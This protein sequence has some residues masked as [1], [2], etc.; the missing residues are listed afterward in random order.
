MLR[1]PREL[2]RRKRAI[3][4]GESF[5]ELSD[6]E[7]DGSDDEALQVTGV[8]NPEDIMALAKRKRQ[9]KAEKLEKIIAGRTLFETKQRDGGAT[10]NEKKRTKNFMM[11]KYS[12]DNRKKGSGKTALNSK[13]TSKAYGHD[14]RKR[15]RKM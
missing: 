12:R 1:D 11:S 6:D 14:A 5:V 10:N 3:A 2:A 13:R 7:S 4:R 15:R 9:S 8:V